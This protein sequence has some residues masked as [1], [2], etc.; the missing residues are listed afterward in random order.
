ML[1]LEVSFFWEC[2]LTSETT[3]RQPLPET[4][5]LYSIGA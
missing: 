2:G 3:P 4:G 1:S 5:E